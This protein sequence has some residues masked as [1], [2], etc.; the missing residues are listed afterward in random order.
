VTTGRM[1]LA[2]VVAAKGVDGAE[3]LRLAGALEHASEHPIAQAIAKAATAEGGLPE[4]E[5]FSSIPGHGVSGVAEG[6]AV[7]VGNEALL[8]DWA[9]TLPAEL[10]TAK[11]DAEAT[12]QTAVLVAWDGAVRGLLVVADQV[13]PTSREAVARLRALGLTPVL[14]TGDNAAVARTIPSRL[15][16]PRA[17]SSRWSA[18]A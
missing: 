6:R 15:C 17:A 18:T 1:S 16:R 4:V 2:G 11:R 5:S 9:L 14:L 10:A 8:A 12:G 3:L 13:K 7:V